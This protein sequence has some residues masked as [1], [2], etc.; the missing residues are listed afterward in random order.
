MASTPRSSGATNSHKKSPPLSLSR[1]L[2]RRFASTEIPPSI[3][4]SP[5]C[6]GP[7]APSAVLS[8]PAVESS[9]KTSSLTSDST[10]EPSP[11][12]LSTKNIRDASPP[13]ALSRL[14]SR[15]FDSTEISDET[16]YTARS[17]PLYPSPA[18]NHSPGQSSHARVLRPML[19]RGVSSRT[20]SSEI[21]PAMLADV[22]PKLVPVTPPALPTSP[23]TSAPLLSSQTPSPPTSSPL[24][25]PILTS[26]RSGPS[27]TFPEHKD[28]SCNHHPPKKKAG[29]AQV[30]IIAEDRNAI[31][32]ELTAPRTG[33]QKVYSVPQPKKRL[34]I[35]RLF[36]RLSQCSVRIF[37]SCIIPRGEGEE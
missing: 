27:P 31:R 2:S 10:Q 16:F 23:V 29:A 33:A 22:S 3:V 12:K 6:P 26:S 8:S 25:S 20:L 30:D 24:V 1:A 28:Q 34:S 19:S 13:P 14:F 21:T 15:R 35:R 32:I 36:S 9:P 18:R 37:A 17:A 11:P 4:S 7:T 5:S